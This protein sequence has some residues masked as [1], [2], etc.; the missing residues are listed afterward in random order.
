M[1][2][3]PSSPKPLRRAPIRRSLELIQG[4]M[5]PTRIARRSPWLAGLHRAS[6]GALLGLGVAMLGLSALTLYWQAH[7]ARSYQELETSQ[8][9]EH[10]LQEATAVLEQ[11]HLGVART[12]GLVEPTSSEKLVYLPA[13][14]A[15]AGR[16][17]LPLLASI[18]IDRIPSGY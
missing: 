5:S 7:W 18:Q 6:D 11:H 8:V 10:R 12:P 17:G 14:Q 1:L 15:E 16:R 4:S 3:S 9:L 13:P 2:A